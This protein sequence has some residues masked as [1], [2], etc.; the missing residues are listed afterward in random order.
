VTR[1]SCGVCR[2][3][4]ETI[5]GNNQASHASVI[6]MY[7]HWRLVLGGTRSAYGPTTDARASTTN[8]NVGD[9]STSSIIRLVSVGYNL[10]LDY[11]TALTVDW[12]PS[13]WRLRTKMKTYTTAV[14]VAG[15]I[16]PLLLHM[17]ASESMPWWPDTVSMGI[18]FGTAAI[19]M[20][21]KGR[22]DRETRRRLWN[23]L[24]DLGQAI[25]RSWTSS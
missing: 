22:Q 25:G 17:V 4:S 8:Q 20:V 18:A 11:W 21:W 3:R 23:A 5:S 15:V 9:L 19:A 10:V 1:P 6:A 24:R 14:V 13:A 2:A 16:I 12:P 7:S